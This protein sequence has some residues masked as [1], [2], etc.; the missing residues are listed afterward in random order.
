M[1]KMTEREK[2]VKLFLRSELREYMLI[3]GELMAEEKADLRK[4]VSEG[5]SCYDNPY[6]LY[7]ESGRSMDFIS[8]CRMS[9]DQFGSPV[10]YSYGET[11]GVCGE[12]EEIPF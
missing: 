8:G 5:N 11:D 3:A 2:A 7:D 6:A 4:W 1:N 9:A 10:D 12:E